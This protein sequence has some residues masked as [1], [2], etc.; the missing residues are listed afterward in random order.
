M[1]Q[2]VRMMSASGILGYGFPES[3]LQAA[4]A[5][6]PHMI[7]VDGG[8]SDPGPHYLG[9]GKTLNS[10]LAMKRDL[11]LL[12]RG[13]IA[14]GI[15]M[16]VGTCGGAGGEP[17][18]QA[19]AEIIREIAAEHDLH[20]KMALIHAEQ[21]KPF[22]LEQLAAGRIK[23]I[24]GAPDLHASELE[25]AVRV[26]GMMGPEPY[27]QALAA[28]AQ[29]ILGGRG[30]DPAPWVALAMHH[31]LPEAPA[32]YAGKILECACN[33]AIPK[34]H[35]CLMVTVGPDFVETEPLNPELR[36][37]PLSVAV[38]ALHEN[39]SPITRYEP[40][41][42][43]DSS[44]C[45][46]EALTDRRVR[47]SG[48]RW[49]ARPY[50]IKLEGV[51]HAGYSAIALAAT[52][53]PGLIG[54]IDS[55]MSSVRTATATKVAALG[56]G[57]DDYRLVLRQYGRNGVMGAWEPEQS[58]APVEVSII[59][60]VVART[61]DIANA[62]LSLARVTLLHSD[63]PGRMCREGNMAFPFSPSD[64]ERGPIYEF[65]LQHVLEINDPLR[66]FPVEYEQV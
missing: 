35:D 40:G 30:T 42:I 62:A 27:R 5:L 43:V 11:S 34:K 37:T 19:C 39:A 24:G 21:D 18:L 3:S 29:V 54:Q 6:K 9:S 60:E 25:Q 45:R 28:G 56:I 22:L 17:H 4:L 23:P 51:R 7:G 32:W 38:Q 46:I 16:M 20:F 36:C 13:A 26:V 2:T 41:G 49:L 33:A 59:A 57:P 52:R 66:M 65:M 64:I 48:M 10:R 12:L 55:F 1:T 50:S 47:I 31:G 8:S 61:Q 53:D 15:P 44:D 63:F 14:N 58:A